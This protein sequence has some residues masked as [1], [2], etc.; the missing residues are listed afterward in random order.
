MRK[1]VLLFCGL[2]LLISILFFSNVARRDVTKNSTI[3]TVPPA[4]IAET[5]G[6]SSDSKSVSA[7]AAT[8]SSNNAPSANPG[9][10]PTNSATPGTISANVLKQIG[11]LQAAKLQRTAAQRKLDSQLIDAEKMR[12]GEPIAEGIP[13]LRFDLDKDD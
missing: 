11:A 4:A 2:F 8:Q 3:A 10:S 13:A 6:L 7:A 12:R 5:L 9:T 1:L